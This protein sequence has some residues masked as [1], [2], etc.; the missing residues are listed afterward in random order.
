MFIVVFWGWASESSFSRR[1]A[2]EIVLC[3]V[4][5]CRGLYCY[6][7]R[8]DGRVDVRAVCLYQRGGGGCGDFCCLG[9]LD[10]QVLFVSLHFVFLIF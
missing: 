10:I 3:G 1:C 5:R 9:I 7:L 6:F 2:I 4:M 8:S